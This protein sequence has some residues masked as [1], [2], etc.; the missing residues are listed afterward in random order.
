VH[1]RIVACW[2]GVWENL[3]FCHRN[4]SLLGASETLG[5]TNPY[6]TGSEAKQNAKIA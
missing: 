1:D 5:A 6:C 4:A 3:E 2:V